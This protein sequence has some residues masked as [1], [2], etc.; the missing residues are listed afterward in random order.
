MSALETTFVSRGDGQALLAGPDVFLRWMEPTDAASAPVWHPDRFPTPVE[1]MRKRIERQL[2]DDPAREATSQRLI[3]CRRRDD[4]PLGSVLFAYEN[5]RACVLRFTHDPNRSLDERARTEADVMRFSLPFLIEKRSLMKVTTEHLGDHPLVRDTAKSL[6][7]RRCY[8]LREAFLHHG[9]RYDR[10]G[11]EFLNPF[12]VNLLGLPR[13]MSEDAENRPIP[14][15][16]P[17]AWQ[18]THP[19]SPRAILATDRIELRT[20]ESAGAE[21]ASQFALRE[22]EDF[23]PTGPPLRNP[24]SWGQHM[25]AIARQQPPNEIRFA[26]VESS[27][28]QVFGT[29]GVTQLD[30]LDGRG[31]TTVEIV[32]PDFR[33]RGFGAD[34]HQLLLEFLFGRLGLHMIY[35]WVSEFNLRS[36]GATRKRGYREAGYLAWED[37]SPSGYCG[38]FY[39]DFL[40]S[41][42]RAART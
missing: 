19:I 39:L 12:W 20:F 9:S 16:A 8:R 25:E 38:G 18:P 28:E 3:M 4:R 31:K 32:R 22:T 27:T 7:L 10:I 23:Y 29:I 17:G 14:S 41:E 33:G 6:G 5:E 13:G 30:L 36:L 35:A 34:A 37:L 21:L 15:H 1:V 26:L 24:W 2:G 11:Y 40:A 42:W